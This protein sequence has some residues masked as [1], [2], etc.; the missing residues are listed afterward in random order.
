[1]GII[2]LLTAVLLSANGKIMKKVIRIINHMF[3]H[4]VDSVRKCYIGVM[5]IY[6]NPN[7]LTM[8]DLLEVM[9]KYSD[10]RLKYIYR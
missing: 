8:M 2:Q 6:M 3:L 5:D 10:E 4:P 1:M 9:L 7:T